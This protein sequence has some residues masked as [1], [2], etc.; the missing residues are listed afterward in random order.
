MLYPLH[1]LLEAG[2]AADV[3]EE[4]IELGKEW[5]ITKALIYYAFKP[6]K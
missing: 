4:R 1:E 2:L 3:F 5:I 6:I